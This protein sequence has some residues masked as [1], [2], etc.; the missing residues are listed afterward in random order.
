MHRLYIYIQYIYIHTV[1]IQIQYIYSV[2]IYTVYIYT[3]YTYLQIYI[4]IDVFL[5]SL[6]TRLPRHL[7]A[8]PNGETR[9]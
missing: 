3:V 9:S 4:Y 2:Y 7:L 6:K 1:Y 5:G 8:F